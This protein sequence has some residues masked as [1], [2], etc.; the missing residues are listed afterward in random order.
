MISITAVPSKNPAVIGRL[1]E[2]EAVLVLPS[3]G[4]IK[5]LNEVGARIWSLI[6]GTRSLAR[7]AGIIE[8]EFETTAAQAR[9][10]ILEFAAELSAKD[11]VAFHEKPS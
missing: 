9:E 11:L 7:I 5:V 6:D 1:V 8:Q 4:K 3:Q 10:D 2:D